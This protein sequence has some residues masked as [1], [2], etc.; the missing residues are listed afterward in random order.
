MKAMSLLVGL[1]LVGCAARAPAP[2][3]AE[4]QRNVPT[5]TAARQCELMFAA[6]RN[7]LTSHCGIAG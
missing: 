6:G 4:F 5:C 2:D 7:W 1:F 3:M